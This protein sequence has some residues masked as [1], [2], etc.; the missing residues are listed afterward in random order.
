MPE[1]F[2]DLT[3]QQQS[4][5]VRSF[6]LHLADIEDATDWEPVKVEPVDDLKVKVIFSSGK[7][8]HYKDGEWDE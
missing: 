6:L 3:P 4:S 1:G 5:F 8:L 7:V 2:T